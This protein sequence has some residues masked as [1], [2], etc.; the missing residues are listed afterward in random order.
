[1]SFWERAQRHYRYPDGRPT[2]ELDNLRDALRPLRRLYG[3]TQARDFGPLALRAVQQEMERAGLCRTVINDRIKRT[4]RAFR[5]AVSVELIPP[6]VV[7]ALETVLPLRRGRCDARESA[8]VG[9]VRWEDVVAILPYLPRQ[10]SAMV[11]VMRY[12]N[13][14]AEDIVTMRGCDLTMKGNT[15][16]YRPTSHKNAWREDDSPIHKRIV[17]LGP[18][19]QQVISPFLKPDLQ[20]YLFSPRESRGEY[21]NL[22]ALQR[23]SKKT[24]SELKRKWKLKPNRGPGER[25]SVNSFQQAVRKACRKQSMPIW[26]VLQV[27]HTRATEVREQYGV[28]GAQASP[29]NARVEAAQIYAEKNQ[30]LAKKIAGEIG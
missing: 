21:Q 27:R 16:E 12:S 8:G 6:S 18:C 25:Y 9:P 2:R 26:T 5:W 29:G 28:E 17:Y 30:Q 7:Q 22:R 11:Q 4:R 10:V 19:C 23:Q 14:R 20:A 13:C 24:P 3:H 1:M 15:W